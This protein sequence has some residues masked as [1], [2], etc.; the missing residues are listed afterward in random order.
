MWDFALN[1][2]FLFSI[3]VYILIKAVENIAVA[4][5]NKN[6]PAHFCL[7]CEEEVAPSDSDPYINEQNDKK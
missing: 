1:H 3:L 5:I 6:K 4:F 2:Y 7:E